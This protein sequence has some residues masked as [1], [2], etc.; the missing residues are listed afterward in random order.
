[1]TGTEMILILA[2][3]GVILLGLVQLRRGRTPENGEDFAELRGQLAQMASQSNELQRLIAEQM[4][5]SEGR[6]GNRLEQSL[7][8][9]NERTTKSLT[10]M[11]EKLAVITEANTH[12]SALSTQVTQLQNILSNK[13]A[14]GSFGEVQLEN[15]VRDALPENAFDFQ[16]TLGNGRRVDCLLRLPNPPGPI[17]IDSKFPLEAYRRL[18]GAE[19][20]AEREA[21]RRLLEIDVKKHIQDIAEKYIIPGETAESAILFLPSESV[22]AEINIQLPKL[23]EA[24]RKARVYMAGPD[25]L[26]LLLHTVRAILRDARMHEAAGLIQTQVDLMMKDVH[27]LEERVGKLATHLSQAE[28]D[29][30]DIQT[31]TRKIISRGDKIDEIEVLDADQAAPAV[32]KPN[33]IS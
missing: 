31:S 8:D 26:M 27:R 5:Q 23:V 1:M 3:L 33:M 21:A 19:N 9:Q 14:R 11:A 2:L 6:L 18:T 28:N 25:N 20:D 4:A 12:I 30:S 29:I 17:A 32:A 13:Q 10:G 24:S 7:R 16:A 15:L 22:Y